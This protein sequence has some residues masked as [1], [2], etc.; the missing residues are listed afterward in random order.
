MV[1]FF[2]VYAEK[3]ASP[4]TLPGKP[5][6][7]D[8]AKAPVYID[9][10]QYRAD[11]RGYLPAGYRHI[12]LM[13]A[14]GGT[15]IQ[16]TSG[17]FDHGGEISW[18][19]DSKAFYFSANRQSDKRAQAQNSEVYKLTIADKNLTQVTDRF[20]PDHSPAL[21]SD[22]KWLAYLGY[23]DKKL[24]H[25][26]DQ[27]YVKN[28]QSGEVKALT[29]DLDRAIDS[30]SW[31]GDSDA[32]YIQYDDEAQGKIALQPLNGKRKVLVDQVG[33][34]SYSRPY[35]GSSFTVSEDGDIAYTQMSTQ[36]PA[37]LALWQD[38][39]RSN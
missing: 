22:G 35:T 25:Q 39:K 8:W 29:T 10:M 6:K 32:L 7:N 23:D 30:F 16:L 19:N 21:S 14:E 17:D 26:A 28:L 36:A 34:S 31:S 2:H 3:V 9:T 1:S 18:Q 5:E 37:E 33:G 20:G 38:G 27:L 13:A 11:G 12:Y 24:A 4:V 15:P